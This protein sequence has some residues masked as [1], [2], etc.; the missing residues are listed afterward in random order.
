MNNNPNHPAATVY[1]WE[2]DEW[3]NHPQLDLGHGGFFASYHTNRPA[4][5]STTLFGTGKPLKDAYQTWL[6]KPG[7]VAALAGD[8]D[9]QEYVNE[10]KRTVE[11][12]ERGFSEPLHAYLDLPYEDLKK[13]AKFIAPIL[14]L[15]FLH[16]C[17]Y[18][19][20][21]SKRVVE[22]IQHQFPGEIEAIPVQFYNVKDIKQQ[23][24]ALNVLQGIPKPDLLKQGLGKANIA[25]VLVK[26]S[27]TKKFKR[28][29]IAMSKALVTSF[30][31]NGFRGMAAYPTYF[32]NLRVQ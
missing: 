20:V 7:P 16:I 24:Y 32:S 6:K 5:P 29:D 11:W 4:N 28:E 8:D 30:K 23:F 25:S 17:L 3:L 13:S 10:C 26:S 27:V 31:T 1:R 21:A 12:A 2:A 19:K 22:L 14:D 18:V 15:D 9:D